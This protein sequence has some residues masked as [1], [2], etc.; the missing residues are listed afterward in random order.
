MKLLFEHSSF[1]AVALTDAVNE[2]AHQPGRLSEMGLFRATSVSTTEVAIERIGNRLQLVRQTPRGAPG[3]V[4]DMPKRSLNKLAIP[5][6]Q[7]DWHVYA[8]EV[9]GVRDFGSEGNLKTFQTLVAEKMGTHIADF[10]V[11]EEH[12]RLGAVQGKVVYKG[13]F[14]LD[15][16]ATFGASEPAPINFDLAAADP[17]D[18]A[19]R[20]K[21][22]SVIRK[23]RAA[24]GGAPFDHVHAFVGDDFFDDLLMH[25]EVRETYKGWSAATILRDS[26]AGKSRA[27]NPIFEYG[28]IVWEN[29]GAVNTD[30]DAAL[31]GIDTD[32]ARFFP[33][34]T[35]VF[36]TYYAPADYIES[37]N[38][39]GKRLYAKQWKMSNDKGMNG[40]VQMNALQICTRPAVLMSGIRT[41]A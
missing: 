10:E 26:Y 14:E 6:F 4:R 35:N 9:E 27:S 13:G 15:L 41:A 34:G 23:M 40:E 18:G 2:I 3:E 20:R 16:F 11:T 22:V 7:R 8:D 5:H 36:R 30:G 1:T 21:C 28:G 31:I 39:L 25:R 12:Q 38:M 33:V 19:L 24:L 29:Y 37:V 17:V 32:K